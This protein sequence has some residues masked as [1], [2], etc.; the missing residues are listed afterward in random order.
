MLVNVILPLLY[1]ELE[2]D[3]LTALEEFYQALPAN[4]NSKSR[5]LT[6]RFF[7]ETVKGEL[8]QKA[9]LEQGAY[10]LH[11]DFCMHYEASCAGCPFIENYQAQL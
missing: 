4:K 9:R 5:Y 8:L 7:G 11:R 6:H 2:G 3:S 10:Q 1:R